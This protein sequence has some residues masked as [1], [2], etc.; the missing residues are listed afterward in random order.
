MPERA[1]LALYRTSLF[2]GIACAVAWVTFVHVVNDCAF[3][4]WWGGPHWQPGIRSGQLNG[5]PTT[6]SLLVPAL[7]VT[8]VCALT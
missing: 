1:L 8:L 5:G 6:I 7:A 3:D 4:V 2:Y